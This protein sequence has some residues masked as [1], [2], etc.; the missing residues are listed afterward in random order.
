MSS[1]ALQIGGIVGANPLGAIGIGIG[2]LAL[3]ML[4]YW[5]LNAIRDHDEADEVAED[6]ASNAR[7]TVLAIFAVTITIGDQLLQLVADLVGTI[8]SPVVV[9]HVVGGLLGWFGI[10]GTISASQFVMLFGIVTVI[11][12]I[13]RASTTRGAGL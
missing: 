13:W 12:L 3:I 4:I 6:V 1:T 9:G 2:V 11:A 10:R 7:G 8:D 5:T